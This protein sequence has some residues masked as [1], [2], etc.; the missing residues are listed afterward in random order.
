MDV[1]KDRLA[2]AKKNRPIAVGGAVAANRDR[3]RVF[4]MI[5]ALGGRRLAQ[6]PFAGVAAGYLVMQFGYVFGL[7]QVVLLEVFVLAIGFVLRAIAGALVI[8]RAASRPGST[9]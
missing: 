5:V 1:E 3:V 8:Q 6:P 2:P 7:K 9:S 4:L